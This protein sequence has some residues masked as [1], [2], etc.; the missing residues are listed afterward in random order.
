[1]NWSK[2]KTILIVLFLCTDIILGMGLISSE[3]KASI[4]DAETINTAAE[5][6]SRHGITVNPD[7]IPRKNPDADYIE[8]ENI[9]LDYDAFVN[10]FSDVMGGTPRKTSENTYETDTAV[11]SFSGDGFSL[12]TKRTKKEF[13]DVTA[14]GDYA[15]RAADMAKDMLKAHGISATEFKTQ[16]TE[17]GYDVTFSGKYGGLPIF[18]SEITVTVT[19]FETFDENSELNGVADISGSWF[20]PSAETGDASTLKSV[21]GILIDFISVRGSDEPAEITDLTFGYTIFDSD[22]LHRSATLI[23]VWRITLSD[24]SVHYMDARSSD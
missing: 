24:G 14:K 20:V 2:V 6:L 13:N 23:P 8:A 15:K 10:E 16:K 5:L 3:R 9:I 21:S 18:C 17:Y 19:G 11:M 1:M 12:K 7:L 22:T 4:T